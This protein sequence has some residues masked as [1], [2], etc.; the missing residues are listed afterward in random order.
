MAIG[1]SRSEA[2]TTVVEVGG[3]AFLV[4]CKLIDTLHG[5]M[6]QVYFRNDEGELLEKWVSHE[7]LRQL[8]RD[9]RHQVEA[10]M[11]EEA[12]KVYHHD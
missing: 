2:Q 5:W 4:T 3:R 12:D 7:P 11:I 8:I 9:F 6:N 10:E 1:Q